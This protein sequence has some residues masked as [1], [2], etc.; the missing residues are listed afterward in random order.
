MSFSKIF[1]DKLPSA[2]TLAYNFAEYIVNF[3]NE[4]KIKY[5]IKWKIKGK[6]G[7][8]IRDPQ[9]FYER[10]NWCLKV[11]DKR[12]LT[13][14]QQKIISELQNF[15]IYTHEIY[16]M[17][18]MLNYIIDEGGKILNDKIYIVPGNL[19]SS[20]VR[21][22]LNDEGMTL[23]YQA[24]ILSPLLDKHHLRP[25]LIIIKDLV[26]NMRE[27]NDKYVSREKKPIVKCRALVAD[28]KVIVSERDV[29]QLRSYEELFPEGSV[30]VI[31]ALTSIPEEYKAK[32][33]KWR[34]I[35]GGEFRKEFIKILNTL[36]T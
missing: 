8:L 33:V 14:Y 16:V 7:T 1:L 3:L 22:E 5:N 23:I 26:E 28:A 34:V 31:F 6:T 25:D 12:S 11:I 4:L 30:F 35:V 27:F 21:F 13:P 10:L 36:K 2:P 29:K 32:L 19:P 9:K 18:K 20:C 15:F 24:A 17:C